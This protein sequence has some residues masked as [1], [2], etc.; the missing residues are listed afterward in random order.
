LRRIAIGLTILLSAISAN[1]ALVADY[2]FQNTYSSSV[3]TA[4]DLVPTNTGTTFV[5]DTVNG[6]PRT[7][8]QFP[9]GV[10]LRLSPTTGTIANNT[11]TI[12]M[13]VRLDNVDGYRRL[14]DFSNLA[15]DNGLYIDNGE[16]DFY[17]GGDNDG[18][19][20]ISPDQYVTAVL[21]RTAG[22]TLTGYLNGAEVFQ[23]TDSGNDAVI[24]VNHALHFF[25][26]NSDENSAGAV[27]RIQVYDNVLTATEVAAL[28]LAPSAVSTPTLSETML[29]ILAG[30]L[31]AVAALRIGRL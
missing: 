25:I 23:F 13:L 24:D 19:P 2:E 14:V 12:A 16:L 27:A 20:A 11:Y 8:L 10:G 21:T 5:G 26:D 6:L 28:N 7:V 1:A 9:Q 15:S 30:M 29:L 31:A 3:G 17:V 18:P 4:P 22:G